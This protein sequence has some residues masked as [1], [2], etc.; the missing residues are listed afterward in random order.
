MESAKQTIRFIVQG[1][2]QGVY[3]RQSTREKAIT[4]GLG[5]TIRN[6]DNGTVEVIATGDEE[7]LQHLRQWCREGP[8]RAVVTG[9]TE[10][11]IPLQQFA[12]FKIVH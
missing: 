3:Y 10:E 8:P 4:Y 12:T 1:K 2:V 9:L 11:I 7:S 6:L 5:G